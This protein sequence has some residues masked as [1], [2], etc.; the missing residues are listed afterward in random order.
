MR[1]SIALSICLLATSAAAAPLTAKEMQEL[2]AL[3]DDRSMNPGDY[4]ALVLMEQKRPDGTSVVKELVSYR[5]DVNDALILLFTQPKAEAGKGFLRLDKNLWYYEPGVGDW[6]RS[7]ERMAI[8]GSDARRRDF[9]DS[10]YATEFDPSFVGEE[11]LGNI[12]VYHLQLKAKPDI[13]V[14]FPVE[15]LW[16]HKANKVVLKRQSRAESNRL[17]LTT[18]YLKWKKVKVPNKKEP[19]DAPEEIRIINELQTGYSTT[20]QVQK[21]DMS[22]LPENVFTKAWLESKSR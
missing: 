18:Y 8:G 14:A 19:L 6:V 17:M 11:T 2:L 1:T 15:D 12:A 5:R 13:E 22:G 10:R 16:I 9:D 21:I 4:K 3:I 20:L 7:S